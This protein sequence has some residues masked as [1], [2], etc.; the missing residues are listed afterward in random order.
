[1]IAMLGMDGIE[2]TTLTIQ[3]QSDAKIFALS[4]HDNEL[5]R[6]RM[7]AAGATA[8]MNK[9]AHSIELIQAIRQCI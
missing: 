3:S 7:H 4:M 6:N 1:M 5:L 2:P 9:D 8:Y